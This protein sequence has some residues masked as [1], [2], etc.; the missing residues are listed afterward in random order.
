MWDVTCSFLLPLPARLRVLSQVVILAPEE[1][2]YLTM[3]ALLRP[4]DEV[5]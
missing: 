5:R 4:G 2:I 1:G 3:R